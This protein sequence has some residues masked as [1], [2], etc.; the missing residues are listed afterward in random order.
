MLSV[1]LVG[2]FLEDR[3]KK[4]EMGRSL[5][6]TNSYK[7]NNQLIDSHYLDTKKPVIHS[8]NILL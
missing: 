3:I 7:T 5:L 6:S 8:L 2:F 4:K 1:R